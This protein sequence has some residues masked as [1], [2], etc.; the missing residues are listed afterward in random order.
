MGMPSV[1]FD[2]PEPGAGATTTLRVAV[3]EVP[4]PDR[5]VSDTV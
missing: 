3:L 2:V 4:P 5:A 1:A